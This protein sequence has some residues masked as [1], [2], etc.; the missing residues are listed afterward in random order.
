[1]IVGLHHVQLAAPANSEPELREF[2]AGVL[3]L[4]EVAKPPEL[5]RRGGAWFRGQG[6]E[7]HLGIEAGF[8]P[9]AKAHPAFLVD[10]LDALVAAL[11][12]AVPDQLLPGFRRVYVTDPVGNRIEL[13][14]RT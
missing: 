8:R 12:G 3:G 1:M 9:A 5:A 13:M 6:V 2:Y 11:P 10:D 14:Q 7:I 4:Q